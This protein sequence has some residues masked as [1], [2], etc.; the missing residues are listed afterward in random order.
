MK[1]KEKIAVKRLIIF[2]WIIESLS[3]FTIHGFGFYPQIIS[4]V[5]VTISFIYLITNKSFILNICVTLYSLTTILLLLGI[6]FLY[7]FFGY[8]NILLILIICLIINLLTILTFINY[9]HNK[10]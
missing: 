9:Q 7:L 10:P 4:F 6:I 5:L 8:Q 1:S 3:F 2:Y